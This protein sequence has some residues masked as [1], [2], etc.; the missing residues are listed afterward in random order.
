MGNVESHV[1]TSDESDGECAE[2]ETGVCVR[3]IP[4][5]EADNIFGEEV[6]PQDSELDEMVD[7]IELEFNER[8][9]KYLEREGQLQQ[10]RLWFKRVSLSKEKELTAKPE[11]EANWHIMHSM[12]E[13]SVLVSVFFW[14]FFSCIIFLTGR[15]VFFGSF[16]CCYLEALVTPFNS[17]PVWRR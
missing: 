5:S 16:V 10:G 8:R 7:A 12:P 1:S 3:R 9:G 14:F 11:A 2:N 6:H 4:F 15:Q 13:L 17:L